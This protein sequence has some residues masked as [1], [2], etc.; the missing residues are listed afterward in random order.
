MLIY[1]LFVY[2]SANS[3]FAAL[4]NCR[5]RLSE[6]GEVEDPLKFTEAPQKKARG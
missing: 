5:E 4:P 3:F 1:L 2:H 6:V